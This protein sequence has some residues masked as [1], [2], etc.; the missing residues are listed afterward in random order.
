[1]KTILLLTVIWSSSITCMVN[2]ENQETQKQENLSVTVT[3][4]NRTTQKLNHT[5]TISTDDKLTIGK[6][7]EAWLKAQKMDLCESEKL[8]AL[9]HVYEIDEKCEPLEN[10]KTVSTVPGAG[11]W[12]ILLFYKQEKQQ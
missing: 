1:M 4:Y 8:L 10:T 6:L 5:T 7:K 2:T 9:Q 12:G 3:L 11:K